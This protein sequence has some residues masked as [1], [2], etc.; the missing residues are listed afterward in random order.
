[1]SSDIRREAEELVRYYSEVVR[2]LGQSGVRDV[3]DLLGLFDQLRRALD[4]VSSQEIGWAAD[5]TQRLVETLVRMDAN[6]QALRRL[7]MAFA[8]PTGDRLLEVPS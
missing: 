5:Q 1:M 4:A 2:R 8:A 6:I 7:K 3:A